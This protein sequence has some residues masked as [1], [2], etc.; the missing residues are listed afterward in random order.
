MT[1]IDEAVTNFETL[2]EAN[3]LHAMALIFQEKSDI[4][5]E[6]YKSASVIP[7][8]VINNVSQM[9]PEEKLQEL[10]L[11]LKDKMREYAS[12]DTGAKLMVWSQVA[13]EL[14]NTFPEPPDEKP[15][16]PT[17]QL[18]NTVKSFD[19]EQTVDFLGRIL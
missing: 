8:E 13:R 14:G 12:L 9:L 16:A 11:L 3:Q 19:R 6:D 18:V 17:M 4:I 7:Q 2:G 15:T 5:P 1:T 10:G